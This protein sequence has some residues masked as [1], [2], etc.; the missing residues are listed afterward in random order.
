L[1]LSC[2]DTEFFGKT[3]C[4]EKRRWE[5]NADIRNKLIIGFLFGLVVMVGLLIYTDVQEL[6]QQLK[7]LNWA[8]IPAAL[9]LTL[10]NYLLRFIKWHF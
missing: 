4:L 2:E 3:R 1:L 9:S 5:T 7:R 10:L 8:V 6:G